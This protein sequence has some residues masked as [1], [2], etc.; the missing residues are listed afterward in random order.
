MMNEDHNRL[1]ITVA[2]RGRYAT[3]NIKHLAR[4]AGLPEDHWRH[5]AREL[6]SHGYAE[7]YDGGTTITLTDDG[8]EEANRLVIQQQRV[9]AEAAKAKPTSP[10]AMPSDR[11]CKRCDKFVRPAA[12]YC[13]QCGISVQ[14]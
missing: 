5:I 6:R 4:R 12:L 2:R 8:W 7:S 9:A 13:P 11:R 1:L 3:A 10:V 14:S